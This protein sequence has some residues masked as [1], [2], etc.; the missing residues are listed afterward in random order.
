VLNDQSHVRDGSAN[1]GLLSLLRARTRAHDVPAA[2]CS[3]CPGRSYKA[4]GPGV[5]MSL[6]ALRAGICAGTERPVRHERNAV[7]QH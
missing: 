6:T 5:A 4:C 2:Q 1:F 7:T 3:S